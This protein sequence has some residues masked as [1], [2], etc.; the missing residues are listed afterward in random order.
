M[1]TRD[2][3][4]EY[5]YDSNDSEYKYDSSSRG[6]SPDTDMV[7]IILLTHCMHYNIRMRR[8]D[9]FAKTHINTWENAREW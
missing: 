6:S 9:V 7:I 4:S 2:H 5:K 8:Y 3:D 1:A